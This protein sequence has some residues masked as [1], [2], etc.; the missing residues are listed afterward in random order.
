MQVIHHN[1]ELPLA[2]LHLGMNCVH[3]WSFIVQLS[4]YTVIYRHL[5]G[6]LKDLSLKHRY[7]VKWGQNNMK[8]VS[9]QR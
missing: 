6:E 9:I 2:L 1:V 7:S 5:E 3:I 4:P 8:V